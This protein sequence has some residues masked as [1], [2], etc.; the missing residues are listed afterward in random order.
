MS[1]SKNEAGEFL[2]DAASF[3]SRG[4]VDMQEFICKLFTTN[5]M[6]PDQKTRISIIELMSAVEMLLADDKRRAKIFYRHNCMVEKISELVGELKKCDAADEMLFLTAVATIRMISAAGLTI[7]DRIK[8][9][10]SHVTDMHFPTLFEYIMTAVAV[11][12]LVANESA[13]KCLGYIDNLD[14]VMT[15]LREKCE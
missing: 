1:I 11:A 9:Q 14:D 5:N 2:S 7:N 15:T 3:F 8:E 13:D 10:Y 4:G 6:W 12:P